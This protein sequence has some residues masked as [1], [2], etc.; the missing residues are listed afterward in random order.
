M[1]SNTQLL[2]DRNR[3]LKLM[4]SCKL[5]QNVVTQGMDRKL[6]NPKDIRLDELPE[7]GKSYSYSQESEELNEDLREAI[8]SNP[9][10]VELHLEKMGGAFQASGS[11]ET[12]QN[13]QCAK[14]GGDVKTPVALKVNEILLIE[15]EMPR[16]S[17]SARVNHSTELDPLAPDVVSLTHPELSVG[18]FI[19]EI[20]LLNEP[21]RP[22]CLKPCENPYLLKNT[23]EMAENSV[24]LSP[25]ADLKDFKL[26]S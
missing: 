1:G 12:F 9:F 20:I 24:N 23:Q 13:L 8:G 19:R 22:L 26:N 4:E 5:T 10:S 11:I 6:E 14:C 16:S 2:D 21:F 18:E 3:P 17:K 15:R 25:F 7:E